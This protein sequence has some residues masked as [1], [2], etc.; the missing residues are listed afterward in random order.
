MFPEEGAEPVIDRVRKTACREE[1][2]AVGT[3]LMH[4]FAN[5]DMPRWFSEA[6]VP[7]RAI[8]AAAPNPTRIESNRKYGDFD[9]VLVENV[10][11]FP[12]MTRP[13]EFNPLLLHAIAE[14]LNGR[15][16]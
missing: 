8:N 14:I 6:G 16:S 15:S 9:A 1:A 13:G 4:D 5:I 11:H 12:H 3:A 2:A 10:G 7:I